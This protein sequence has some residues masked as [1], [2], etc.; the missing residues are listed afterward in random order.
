MIPVNARID[1]GN[2][3]S[4]TSVTICPGSVRADHLSG[5]GGVRLHRV[6]Q[7]ILLLQIHRFYPRH[8]FHL[9]Q[10]P[11]R[12][13]DGNAIDTN[14]EAVSH[15]QRLS[16][17]HLGLNAL[18]SH[19][20]AGHQLVTVGE[21]C[22]VIRQIQGGVA[23]VHQGRVFQD[24]DG[25]DLFVVCRNIRRSLFP[26]LGSLHQEVFRQDAGVHWRERHSG[27]G[28]GSHAGRGQ[29]RQHHAQRQQDRQKA[30]VGFAIRHCF[31]LFPID[32]AA[33]GCYIADG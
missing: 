14:G 28:T 7:L 12:R 18:Q 24:D 26:H 2:P 5:S 6:V 8:P 3:A 29:E 22:L 32:F 17:Q 33:G 31:Y 1:D 23:P 16:L 25:P 20:L 13:R 15:I 11:I 19:F 9:C 30:Q 10:L 21:G 4:R 27:R